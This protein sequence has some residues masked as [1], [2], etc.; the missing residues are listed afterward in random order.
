VFF[1]RTLLIRR[2]ASTEDGASR[3]LATI[4]VPALT[5]RHARESANVL[6]DA[7]SNHAPE[8]HGYGISNQAAEGLKL[9]PFALGNEGVG[10]RKP[11]EDGAFAKRKSP[12]LF[13]VAKSSV[14]EAE[15][16]RGQRG[17]RLVPSHPAVNARVAFSRLTAM[18]SR[19]Q[20]LGPVPPSPPGFRRPNS[21]QVES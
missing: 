14:P 13:G 11:L 10:T 2:L 21:F 15:E 1:C 3:S 5:F 20:M 8:L 16:L 17:R 19:N 18:T 4:P 7:F 12:V 9:N 6:K